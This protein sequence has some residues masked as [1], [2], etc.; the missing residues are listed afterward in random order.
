MPLPSSP[1]P[2]PTPFHQPTARLGLLIGQ[3]VR[4]ERELWPLAEGPWGGGQGM[5]HRQRW[6][7]GLR[8]AGGVREVAHALL[9]LEAALRPLALDEEWRGGEAGGSGGAAAPAAPADAG[10]GAAGTPAGG[11]SRPTSRAVSRAASG[12]DLDSLAGGPSQGGEASASLAAGGD[13]TAATAAAAAAA[14][15]RAADPY[16]T[17]AERVDREFKGTWEMDRRQHA[18]RLRGVNRLPLALVR[19]V[20]R[21]CRGVEALAGR[22]VVL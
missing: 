9:Q 21:A 17:R 20:R 14:A 1:H 12:V 11:A 8:S 5:A 4:L 10:A 22:Q 15:A 2:G 3:L 13:G 7:A 16:E 6:L 18:A 19:K